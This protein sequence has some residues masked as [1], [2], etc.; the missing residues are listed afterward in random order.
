PAWTVRKLSEPTSSPANG[1]TSAPNGSTYSP[2]TSIG[3]KVPGRS[4]DA[5]PNISSVLAGGTEDIDN[6]SLADS[7]DLP[8]QR[9][10]SPYRMLP[11]LPR[12]P[13]LASERSIGSGSLPRPSFNYS[14]PLSRG[15]GPSFDTRPLFSNPYRQDSVNSSSTR[16]SLEVP[17]RQDTGDSPITP[18]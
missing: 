3:L 5:S 1:P 16:P 11:T 17:S 9:S 14:R 4:L 7:F 12:S 10:A 6:L 8:L 2:P 13:S 15:R 18:F